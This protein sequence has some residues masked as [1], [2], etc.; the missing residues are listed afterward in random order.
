MSNE[1]EVLIHDETET[2]WS[3][4]MNQVNEIIVQNCVEESTDQQRYKNIGETS[5][6]SALIIGPDFSYSM[7]AK[8][9]DDKTLFEHQLDGINDAVATLVENC[10]SSSGNLKDRVHFSILG[11]TDG[12]PEIVL[13][14]GPI[15]KHFDGSCDIQIPGS[16]NYGRTDHLSFLNSAYEILKNKSVISKGSRKSSFN[17]VLIISDGEDNVNNKQQIIDAAQKL[18]SLTA[19]DGISPTLIVPVYLSDTASST[20]N[21][22]DYKGVMV[23]EMSGSGEK[24]M[25]EIASEAPLEMLSQRLSD[26]TP[27]LR[28]GSKLMFTGGPGVMK[29]ALSFIAEASSM[30]Q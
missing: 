6:P 27:N 17:V 24:L 18:K 15:S 7:D 14:F 25:A 5:C 16:P 19:E 9:D 22:T 28:K 21:L 12:K 1:A 3:S 13:P 29:A 20:A 8:A 30:R 2:N 26:I 23:D 10:S 11:I 4:D